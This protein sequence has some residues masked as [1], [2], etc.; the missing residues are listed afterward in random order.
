MV[1]IETQGKWAW[2]NGFK[3]IELIVALVNVAKG[4]PER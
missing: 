3:E 1:E 2:G 4:S